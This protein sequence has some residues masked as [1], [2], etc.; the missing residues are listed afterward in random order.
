M[1]GYETPKIEILALLSED[2]VTSSGGGA[3][4]TIGSNED[5]WPDIYD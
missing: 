5:I 1:Q 2:V 3:N 4:S